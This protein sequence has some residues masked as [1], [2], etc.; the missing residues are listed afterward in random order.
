MEL[1][2]FFIAEF[3]GDLA[4]GFGGARGFGECHSDG[5]RAE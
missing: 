4:E 3:R 1:R 2:G 5:F